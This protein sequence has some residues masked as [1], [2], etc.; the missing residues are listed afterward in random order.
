MIGESIFYPTSF[1]KLMPIKA[2]LHVHTNCSVCSCL[3]P[4]Q[5]VKVALARGIGCIA[6]TDHN[7]LSGALEVSRQA[8]NSLKV[9]TG[10]EI[11]TSEGE[12][13][14]YFLK[15][16]IPPLLTP[17]QTI[18][19]IKEQGGLVSVP[20]PF[21]ALRSSR[22]NLKAL[23]SVINQID[24]I[25]VFNSRDILTRTEDRLLEEVFKNGVVGIAASD[26][27]LAFEIGRSYMLID[28]FN[29][30]QEFMCN[31]KRAGKFTRKSPFWVH[32]ATK[33]LKFKNKP[34]M[35]LE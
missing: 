23:H 27:H 15:E 13:T 30:P 28:D 1:N 34:P 7:T 20:H 16:K 24:M 19:R 21:D 4:E 29:S 10:E 18:T 6:I 12:I 32:L 5:V 35:P 9:I 17:Q 26:A 25:E 11:R 3:K 14:G 22:L 31:I 2:D 8:A 33:I